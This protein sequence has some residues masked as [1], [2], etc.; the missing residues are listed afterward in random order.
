MDG[1]HKEKT[2]GKDG[3][4]WEEQ[5]ISGTSLCFIAEIGRSVIGAGVKKQ[6]ELNQ[7]GQGGGEGSQS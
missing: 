1:L 4:S 5:V 2:T 7:K 3:R 6:M